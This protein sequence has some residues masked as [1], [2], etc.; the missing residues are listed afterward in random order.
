MRPTVARQGEG[1]CAGQRKVSSLSSDRKDVLAERRA[2]VLSQLVLLFAQGRDPVELAEDAVQLVARATD[3]KAV[4][5]Y[6]WDEED[7]R[8]VLRVATQVPQQTGIDE[9]RLRLGEG[10]AGWAAMRQESVIINRA[11]AEDPRFIPFAH[12]E[13]EEFHSVL[14]APIADESSNLRG[15][16]A[17]YST[18]EDAF[19]Q[20]ELAIAVEVG[21]LL[22]TGLARAETVN[23]LNHQSAVAH[24]L[25]DFPTASR[26]SLVPALEFA[27]QRVLELVDGQVCVL[28]YM[29]RRENAATP[30][31]F[32]SRT[33]AGQRVWSTHSRSAA[34]SSIEQHCAGLEHMSVALGIGA[35]RGILTCYRPSRFR[36]GDVERL[37]AL[38]MQLGV[39]LEAV[40]LNSVGSSLA[41]RL[42]FT[43]DDREAASIL[44][45]LGLDGPV[46]PILVRV[47]SVQTDWEVASRALKDA[48]SVAAGNRAVVLLHST[49]GLVL[50]DAPG[51]R[52]APE[53]SSHVFQ[54][55]QRLA[56]STG[57]RA[58]IGV[59]SVTSTPDGIRQ[60]IDDARSALEWAGVYGQTLPVSLATYPDVRGMLPLSE[61]VRQLA[62]TVV[63]LVGM[64]E[65]LV[66]YDLKQGTRL[67]KTLAVLAGWGGSVQETAKELLIHRN[68]LRQRMQRIEHV[69]G[70]VLGSGTEW[71]PLTLA[72]QVAS[73]RVS[74]TAVGQ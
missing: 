30:I 3:T 69:L 62:P 66:Q 59:G 25:L 15:V 74:R 33:D 6:L 40:D 51:G 50:A 18:E 8:L 28:E 71:S 27:A 12:I 1:V 26:T 47:H 42:R 16:F 72:A 36:S 37:S 10:I 53:L 11:P 70:I 39:L 73:V 38:A 14:A 5:V 65:P 7:E 23:D 46:C 29:S 60:A 31:M 55:T 2:T 68:T 64:L 17:L 63:S 34:Q 54:A 24:F 67:V 9:I 57:L 22:A 32:A 35:S 45:E 48:L 61:V 56:E 43:Q 19:G 44:G 52:L 41:T 49:W 21:R 58:S 20:D 4:F 13:E